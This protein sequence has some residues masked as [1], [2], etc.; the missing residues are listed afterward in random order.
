MIF[1][2][3]LSDTLEIKYKKDFKEGNISALK[4]LAYYYIKKEQYKKALKTLKNYIK[5][6][7]DDDSAYDLI[8]R[9]YSTQRDYKSA[10]NWSR[11]AYLLMPK[12]INFLK[13]QAIFLEKL[14]KIDDALVIYK[15]V[16][17]IDSSIENLVNYAIGLYSKFVHSKSSHDYA[18]ALYYLR[19][20]DSIISKAELSGNFDTFLKYQSEHFRILFALTAMYNQNGI[21]DSAIY[22]GMRAYIYATPERKNFYEYLVKMLYKYEKYKDI[23]EVCKSVLKHYSD[24]SF[25]YEYM[26][27]AYYNLAKKVK[28]DSLYLKAIESF[29]I[30]NEIVFS[31]HIVFFLAE[32]YYNLGLKDKALDL[33][34]KVLDYGD[35]YKILKMY[36]LLDKKEFEQ[37][38]EI[39]L[40]LNKMNSSAYSILA[41]SFEYQNKLKLAEKYFKNAL[42]ADKNN[43]TRYKNLADF[44]KRRG[45]YVLY[46]EIL[47]EYVQ[48]RPD[49]YEAN[50]QLAQEYFKEGKIQ[51][52]IKYY[53]M[54]IKSIQ[55]I[56]DTTVDKK[57]LNFASKIYNNYGYLLVNENLDIEKGFE[58]LKK[59]IQLDPTNPK[60]LD[61]F[62][63]ALFKKGEYE[64]A[65]KYI[66]T[67][68]EKDQNDS[69]IRNHY[70]ILKKLLNKE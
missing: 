61:S 24:E 47:I 67:A 42:R 2:I 17:E 25:F 16:Y 39:A 54:S 13:Y 69:E 21:K 58:L 5:Y 34:D 37:L 60:I 3:L 4:Q 14:S 49:D 40:T 70:E 52:A 1:L 6:R 18:K 43:P 26:G 7:K 63:W 28:L 32:A 50:F 55:A 23:I 20:S 53:E 64:E 35:E 51:T 11:K 36:I 10:Y 65:F 31:P 44:Y 12:N 66:K 27:Y 57:I 8:I 62:G 56:I 46:K 59:A 15:K 33:I 38:K 9:I 45:N 41:Y 30:A 29:T 48:K 68:Y 22:Y 19:L